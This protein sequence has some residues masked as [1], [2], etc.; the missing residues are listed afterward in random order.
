MSQSLEAKQID[1]S[2]GSKPV[3]RGVTFA[4]KEGTIHGFVGPNGA[5]KSTTMEIAARL[6]LPTAGDVYIQGKSVLNNPFFNEW[7]GS[8]EA[9]P[10]FPPYMTVQGYVLACANLRNVPE[11][12][13]LERL[14]RSDLSRHSNQ[15]CN[16][17]STGQKKMLQLF[18]VFATIE[19]RGL[20]DQSKK[21]VILMDEPF[22]GLD[23]DNRDLL[24]NRLHEIKAA[25]GSIL[26][27]T[28]DLDDLQH[29]ADDITMIKQGQIVW[30]G[31]KT[32]DI[33]DTYRKIFR[34]AESRNF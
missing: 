25:G 2:Y 34:T 29:L 12:E 32:A 33:K 18:A 27:S 6:V 30:T 14:A 26:I 10:N 23:F 21:I 15:H 28:H 13:V 8:V 7:L 24:T 5:G 22:N 16:S 3:L 11:K 4:V 9:E 19:R 31:A 17:L 20:P 1:K